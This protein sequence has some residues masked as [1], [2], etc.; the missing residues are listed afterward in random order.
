MKSIRRIFI[1]IVLEQYNK[2]YR[3]PGFKRL[4]IFLVSMVL[5]NCAIQAQTDDQIQKIYDFY[6]Q[7]EVYNDHNLIGHISEY[8]DISK[9]SKQKIFFDKL[10]LLLEKNPN[11]Q[12]TILTL[13]IDDNYSARNGFDDLTKSNKALKMALSQKNN[14]L[15]AIFYAIYGNT[16]QLLKQPHNAIFYFRKEYDILSQKENN[17]PFLYENNCFYLAEV[18][19]QLFEYDHCIEFGKKRLAIGETRPASLL[20]LG[21]VHILDLIGASYKGLGKADSSIYYYRSIANQIRDRPFKDSYLN[22]LWSSIVSGNIGEN[23]LNQGK[24]P[25]ARSHIEQYYNFNQNHNDHYNVLLSTNLL[26][27][28]RATDGKNNEAIRLWKFVMNDPLSGSKPDLLIN[29]SKGLSGSYADRGQVDSALIYQKI[30]LDKK[31]EV[32]RTIYQSGLEAA[33]TRISF[34]DLQ[35]SLL[36]SKEIISKIK[37]S[38]N[39]AILSLILASLLIVSLSFWNRSRWKF[40]LREENLQRQMAEQKINDSKAL[41]HNMT[42]SL[43]EKSNMVEHLANQIQIVEN[44]ESSFNLK[45]QLTDIAITSDEGWDRFFH[46]FSTVNPSFLEKLDRITGSLSPAELRLTVL[47]KVG[48]NNSQ[49]AST[50][51]ISSGSVVKSKYRLKQKLNLS[52]NESLESFLHD[53]SSSK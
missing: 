53:L 16:L 18:L 47:I 22:E 43:I 36:H 25:E 45:E 9:D 33:E 26:A 4:S 38:R 34:E 11:E 23:M 50:L 28:L 6:A 49:L 19:Y 32:Q 40:R 15:I 46:S 13:A 31:A 21:K 10:Y 8:A 20:D 3:A 41:L 12:V 5:V 2:L 48:L 24:I 17:N 42:L 29:A 37:L 30:S 52:T 7:K 35:H 51:G 39:L 14:Q 1:F 44:A 27:R